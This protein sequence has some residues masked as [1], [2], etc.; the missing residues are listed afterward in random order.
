VSTSPAK[1]KRTAKN[2]ATEQPGL[3]T[4]ADTDSCDI[5]GPGS[6]TYKRF[7]YCMT[8]V[9][10]LHTIPNSSNGGWDST[11]L[12]VDFGMNDSIFCQVTPVYQDATGTIPVGVCCGPPTSPGR[13]AKGPT[14]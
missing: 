6:Y 1:T 10:V 13:I 2:E 5:A 3:T 11:G 12:T 14:S 9:N 7:E 8:G 4:A